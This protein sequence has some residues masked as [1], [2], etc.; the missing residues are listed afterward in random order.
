MGRS[1][2]LKTSVSD[3]RILGAQY[4]TGNRAE[5]EE[6]TRAAEW[7]AFHVGD[8]PGS[9][10]VAGAEN[11][12]GCERTH[13]ALA[14]LR[15]RGGGCVPWDAGACQLEKARRPVVLEPPEGHSPAHTDS[16]AQGDPLRTSELRLEGSECVSVLSHR[17]CGDVDRRGN[18]HGKGP[19]PLCAVTGISGSVTQLLSRHLESFKRADA[20]VLEPEG[21]MSV[22]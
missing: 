5:L 9:P 12:Q 1:M 20:R 8:H 14:T 15:T 22:G 11:R 6:G 4:V 19:R 2:P 16:L 7:L 17:V 18:S 3:P 21:P 13:Q 10:G